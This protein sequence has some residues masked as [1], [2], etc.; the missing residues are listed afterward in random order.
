MIVFK[1][2]PELGDGDH[3]SV[4]DDADQVKR[5]IRVWLAD[6]AEPGEKFAVEVVEMTPE[7][8]AAVP[9]E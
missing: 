8:F 5:L 9:E 2:S 3:W 7:E 6:C 1:T 4:W